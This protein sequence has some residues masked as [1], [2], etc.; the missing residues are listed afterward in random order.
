MRIFPFEFDF[1]YKTFYIFYT[2]EI[3]LKTGRKKL[4]RINYSPVFF[5]AEIRLQAEKTCIGLCKMGIDLFR[6][7]IINFTLL[8]LLDIL[9]VYFVFMNLYKI[10]KG[11]RAAQ[12]FAGMLLIIIASFIVQMLN[13]EGMSWLIN[14]FASVWVIAFVILFQPELRRLL[15]QIGQSRLIRTLF[16]V[17][18]NRAVNA[19][20]E[21]AEKLSEWHYGA[22]IVMQKDTGLKGIAETGIQLQA[23]VSQELLVSIFFPRTPLHDGA[24]LISNDLIQA[25]K[26]ILPL[27]QNPE[28]DKALGTRHRAA[29]GISEESDAVVVVVSE[30]T[31]RISIAYAGEFLHRNL[32][33]KQLK[34]YLMR[35]FME[36]KNKTELNDNIRVEP[37]SSKAI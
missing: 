30:E 28:I 13:M 20:S 22:L 19:V 7:G 34:E 2:Y 24:V 29:L 26:C 6:I 4:Y 18:E 10:M 23:E 35:L 36:S 12:M 27:T 31:G 25:A 37:I 1:L 8:D 15:I 32:D 17:E 33:G 21:A 16:K 14:S 5:V 11:T 9:A 3:A